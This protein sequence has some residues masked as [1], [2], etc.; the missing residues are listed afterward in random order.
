MAPP[1]VVTEL[2][3]RVSEW[4]GIE[5]LNESRLARRTDDKLA[6]V[7]MAMEKPVSP[8]VPSH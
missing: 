2:V 1:V 4:Y 6:K 8:P 7:I 5:P 3:R